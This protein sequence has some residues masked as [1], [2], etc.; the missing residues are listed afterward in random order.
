MTNEPK[1][2][3]INEVARILRVHRATISRLI[4]SGAFPCIAVGS[5]RL[6]LEKD[7]LSFI[8]NRRRSLAANSPKGA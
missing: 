5:R 6:V 2:L 3:T 8:E 7:L 4:N 1:L